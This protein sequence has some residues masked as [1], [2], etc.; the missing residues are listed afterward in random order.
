MNSCPE[1]AV[2]SDVKEGV[3]AKATKCTTCGRL[4][5]RALDVIS[6]GKLDG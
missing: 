4:K 3:C 6:A 2:M 5:V 1:R